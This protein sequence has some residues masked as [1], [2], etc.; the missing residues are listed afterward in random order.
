MSDIKIRGPEGCGKTLSYGGQTF[1]ADKKGFFSVPSEAAEAL[2]L[3]GFRS[4]TDPDD[5]ETD[6]QRAAREAAEAE[7]AAAAEAARK[8]EE[9]AATAAAAAAG[10]QP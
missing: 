9:E 10:K 5:G 2:K 3:H 8:A 4:S 6:E 1:T 7:A